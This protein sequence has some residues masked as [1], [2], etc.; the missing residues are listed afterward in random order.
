MKIFILF[1]FLSLLSIS[2]QNYSTDIENRKDQIYLSSEKDSYSKQDTIKFY[3]ENNSN[4][5]I[6]IS[7]ICGTYLDMMYQMNENNVW[8]DNLFFGF[9]NLNCPVFLDTVYIDNS[10]TCSLPAN[11]FNSTGIFRVLVPYSVPKEDST[12]FVFSN[13]FEIF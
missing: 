11:K 10:F 13:S 1:F 8:S 9:V 12:M 6:V 4:N 3:L 5:D 2:C 7:L